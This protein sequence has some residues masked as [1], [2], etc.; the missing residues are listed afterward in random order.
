ME[1]VYCVGGIFF[2]FG[3]LV[4]GGLL[5][6]DVFIVYSL[7]MVDVIVQWDI[8]QICDEVVYIFFKVGLVGI[9]IQIVFS[10][11]I[12]W[13]SLDDDCVEG[14]ICS[15]EYVYF[16][17]GGLVVFYGNIVF[18]GC[19][20]KIV[21]VDELI[22]VFEGSVKIFESQDVVVKGIFGDEV[23][24]GDIVIICYE[25][26]KGGLGMQEM[27]YLISYLKFKGLGKQCVLFIDGCF[28]GGILGLFIG[29]VFLEVVVGGVIG[30]V[31]DG[32][33][34]LIDIFNC[35]I[36]LLVSDEEFVVC[37]V[38]QDKKGWKLVVLC[39]C[40]VSIVFKVYVL[41]VISV[42][43]GVVCNK[44]LLDG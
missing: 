4:C 5:Y 41:F 25:G 21:G 34:V 43:K 18:D 20:V 1:D 28:F 30:L 16:K 6:I 26:L 27:F 44:V 32:D 23:K 31:Q 33:K 15:V 3:E 29:Y 17:E 38:E 11:N 10:Q 14:C 36:N 8:I 2:I 42:D 22:Y 7:S 37:C 35:L 13:L 12:C 39:V 24:V 9:L 19:V 40:C